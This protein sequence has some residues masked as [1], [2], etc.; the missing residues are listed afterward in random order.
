MA[1]LVGLAGVLAANHTLQVPPPAAPAP[2]E[3]VITQLERLG[4]LRAQ[5]IL[6]VEELQTQKAK[7]LGM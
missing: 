6:T 3:D 7:L 2:K 1:V 4:A 5:A